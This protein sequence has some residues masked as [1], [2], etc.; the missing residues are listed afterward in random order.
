MRRAI[1]LSGV[2]LISGLTMRGQ[3]AVLRARLVN[4]NVVAV[5][6]GRSG[7]AGSTLDF[8]QNV[9]QTD[10]LV[11]FVSHGSGPAIFLTST[12]AQL[13][14]KDQPGNTASALPD[15]SS[16]GP[17]AAILDVLRLSFVG[18]NPAV[19]IGGTDRLPGVSNYYIG[20]DP[21]AWHTGIP[22]FGK[23]FYRDLYSGIDLL[24]YGNSEGQVEYDFSV[25]RGADPSLIRL[26]FPGAEHPSLDQSDNLL[27]HLS[28]GSIL[29]PA[30]H[31][32]QE[33]D[34][35]RHLVP[36]NFVLDGDT[37]SFSVGTYDTSRPLIIDPEIVYSTLVGGTGSD[38]D[39]AQ[40]IAVDASGNAY[41]CGGTDSIDFPITDGAVQPSLAGSHDTVLLKLNPDG[42]ALLYS[43]Y[44]GGT[45]FDGA[46]GCTVD[47]RGQA[48]VE[49][50]TQSSDFP[51][52]P[53]ALQTTFAGGDAAF[54]QAG[55]DG[56]YEPCDGFVAKFSRS[57]SLIYSTYLGGSGDEEVS[58]IKADARGDVVVAGFT[59]SADFP[60]TPGAYQTL[61][62]GAS[63][64]FVAKL[65]PN[66][67]RLLYATY[68]GGGDEE[69][70]DPGVAMDRHGDVYV[71]SATPS[72]DFPTTPGVFQTTFSGVFDAFVTKFSP[73][74]SA[75]LYSTYLG[76][77]D[78][79]LTTSNL[80]VDALGDV[81][82]DGATASTDF[83]TT[84]EA[85]QTSNAGGFDA[86]ITK[87]NASGSGLIYSTYLG[88]TGDD[89]GAG[90]TVDPGGRVFEA[91]IT[92]STDFPVTG[93]A[94]QGAN[95]GG[96]DMTVTELTKN[97]S[98]VIFSTYLG[99][100]GD[101]FGA[102]LELDH[103]ENLYLDGC[104]TSA[105]FPT[106]PGAFQRTFKGGDGTG[107]CFSSDLFVTKIAFDE[108]VLQ[109]TPVH[110]G[111]ASRT[112]D[113]R[114]SWPETLVPSR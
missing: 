52:T 59:S 43:T 29:Q 13:A 113:G 102:R 34:G 78:F 21:R 26:A 46:F 30:P 48:Y 27:I 54:C 31:I 84:E 24:F 38:W 55:I 83:A 93:G 18:A 36:G 40:P 92:S 62:A 19:W 70:F 88:G 16:A 57:G 87:L 5:S 109:A 51:V 45:A 60:V 106:T 3:T 12:G 22:H 65:N 50:S 77:S 76:G 17:Q 72:A 4:P 10:G 69:S 101:E 23:V 1:A 63:D 58:G 105:D 15:G 56:P 44:L 49:G 35:S 89:F 41:R 85:F 103:S 100:S 37:V 107:W 112:R 64:Y 67:T 42:S 33:I 25:G 28:G 114:G 80:T 96:F 99:G 86:F 110:R 74:L 68:L 97:V 9:G 32:Y 73:T 6:D 79:D 7:P 108:E 82:V 94:F 2:I 20:N 11:K 111:P 71:T 75:L 91:T 47:R 53:G 81:T 39:L 90:S 8:E 61:L 95:A 104:T 14:F 98:G 66:G